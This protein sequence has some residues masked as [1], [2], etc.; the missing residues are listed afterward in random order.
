MLKD[1]QKQMKKEVEK[2]PKHS[3]KEELKIRKEKLDLHQQNQVRSRIFFITEGLIHDKISVQEI[4]GHNLFHATGL[5][6]YR[7]K[8]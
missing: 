5:F 4:F 2:L 3:R 7:M 1:D 8:T 6:L